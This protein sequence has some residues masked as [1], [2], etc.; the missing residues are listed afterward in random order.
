MVEALFSLEAEGWYPIS[1]LPE[2]GLI[3][4]AGGDTVKWM[5]LS[6]KLQEYRLIYVSQSGILQVSEPIVRRDY[7]NL[8]SYDVSAN[9]LT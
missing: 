6:Q 9:Q 8:A 5:T 1:D 3:R 2:D 7:T 4:A